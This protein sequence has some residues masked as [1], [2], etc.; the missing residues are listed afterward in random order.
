MA[1]M[2][3]QPSGD[4]LLDAAAKLDSESFNYFVTQILALQARRRIR[5]LSEAESDLLKQINIGIVL[6][7]W[8][9]YE[10]LK[11]K[12]R[13]ATLSPA[14]HEELIS[15]GNKI[16][17]ANAQRISALSQLAALRHT[18]LEELMDQLGITS[19]GIE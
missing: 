2:I 7:T 16:E 18:S 14:E 8:Q 17:I 13:D 10:E 3:A 15:I 1:T 11:A 9:R 19:P 12:R 5:T 4:E 6:N